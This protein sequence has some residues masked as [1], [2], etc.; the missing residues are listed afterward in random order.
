[1]VRA[2]AL[3]GAS[4]LCG[5]CGSVAAE[6]PEPADAAVDSSTDA[7]AACPS[8]LPTGSCTHEGMRC[9]Y[10]QRCRTDADL[11]P[12][13][14]CS[15]GKWTDTTDGSCARETGG[16]GCPVV[17]PAERSVCPKADTYCTYTECDPADAVEDWVHQYQCL[18]DETGKTA[19]WYN[20]KVVC[21]ASGG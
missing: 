10:P 15:A 20:L 14:L 13:T 1:M 8:F 5:A 3:V 19:R 4:V 11:V 18:Y 7:R 16:D 17:R 9:R 12:A 6:P 21:K 2:L